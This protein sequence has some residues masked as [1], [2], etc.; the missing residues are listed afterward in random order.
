MTGATLARVELSPTPLERYRPLLGDDAFAT[1]HSALSAFAARAQQRVVWNVNSTARGGG[2]AELLASLIP[3]DMAAGADERWVVIE[4]SPDFFAVTKK[5]HTLL[6]GI[7]PDGGEL[8]ADERQ[9]YEET[10]APNASALLAEMRAGDIALLHDPQ[11][12][13]LIPALTERGIKVVWRCHIGVDEPNAV[14]RGAWRFLSP[15]LST[16]S[17][18]VFSRD[19]YVWEGCERSRV[20][21]IA[22]CIDP[23]TSKNRDLG[24]AEAR[25]ILSRSR[26][27]ERVPGSARLVMQVSRWDRLK[28]PVGVL[29]MFALN[30][31][32]VADAWLVLAG[33]Q[34]M[35]V[36]DDPEQPEVLADVQAATETFDK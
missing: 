7:A 34:V 18:L 25:T 29:R 28:D 27:I 5:I 22:P 2:V 12:A 17:A 8:S 15:Y 4:G 9:M 20:R 24:E 21:I 30:V 33:P 36:D 13:G 35:S 11:T 23:F 32:P 26:V 16:A 14:V 10:L 1:F 3:Y 19:A 31:G 6:H